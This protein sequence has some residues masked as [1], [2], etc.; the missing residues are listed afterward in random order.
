LRKRKAETNRQNE[1]LKGRKKIPKRKRKKGKPN[2]GNRTCLRMSGKK[3]AK[4][5]EG[6]WEDRDA[7]E[8]ASKRN[9]ES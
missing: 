7:G 6:Q 3:K 8:I 2:E 4:G 5:T 9:W 1:S